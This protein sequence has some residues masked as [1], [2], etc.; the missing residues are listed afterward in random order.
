M[1]NRYV[2]FL[3]H[4][5]DGTTAFPLILFLHGSGQVG[6]DGRKQVGIVG[7]RVVYERQEEKKP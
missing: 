6:T 2:V 1:A 3:P 4:D 5:Y 7:I